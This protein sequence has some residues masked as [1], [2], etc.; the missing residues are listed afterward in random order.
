MELERKLVISLDDSDSNFRVTTSFSVALNLLEKVSAAFRKGQYN[1]YVQ[2]ECKSDYFPNFQRAK[3]Q[4][5]RQIIESFFE[6]LIEISNISGTTPGKRVN[7][8]AWSAI[9]ATKHTF[10]FIFIQYMQ[11]IRWCSSA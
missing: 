3:W 9:S 1:R 7:W 10:P 5:H 4:N 11:N 8:K 6:A 2:F